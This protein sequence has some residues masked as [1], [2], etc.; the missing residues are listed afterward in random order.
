MQRHA[1]KGS[2]RALDTVTYD[3]FGQATADL[4]ALGVDTQ[5]GQ[6]PGRSRYLDPAGFGGQFGY[7]TDV[8]TGLDLL[9]HRYYD[10]Q[11]GRFVTRD[12]IG[13]R[14]GLNLY[15]FTLYNPVNEHDPSGLSPGGDDAAGY[16]ANIFDHATAAD[17]LNALRN[18]EVVRAV[19]TLA[20]AASYIPLPENP[21]ADARAAGAL[22]K[23]GEDLYVGTYGAAKYGLRKTGRLA[24]YT[25]HHAVQDAINRSSGITHSRG[26]TITLKRSI[27]ANLETTGVAARDLATRRQHLAADMKELRNV[28]GQNGYNRSV[29]NRQLQELSRQNKA[30]GGFGKP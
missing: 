4:A 16:L 30:L 13:Y 17:W 1:Q 24:D 20:N 3:A 8:E 18:N 23:A 5:Y 9:T 22:A 29:V 12:P 27:H 2:A 28:L 6:A 15:S 7:Y 10:P 19:K 14:G 11:Q 25:P 21:E 26:I